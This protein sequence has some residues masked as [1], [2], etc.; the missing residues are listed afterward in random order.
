MT[1]G[2]ILLLIGMVIGTLLFQK[3]KPIFMK[4][5][6][7]GFLL[8]L[9][10]SFIENQTLHTFSF[11]TFGLLSLA[12][13]IYSVINKKWLNL[14]IG[15]FAFVS[16]LFKL[17]HFPLSNELKLM[18]L[19]PLIAYFFILKNPKLHLN[20]LSV[21]TILITYELFIFLQLFGCRI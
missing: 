4:I 10:V 2:R 12:F 8:S 11:V 15:L 20:E 17:F 3:T 16:F 19:I 6:L 21:L 1:F 14:L 18:M 9:S 13:S 7:I 5:I